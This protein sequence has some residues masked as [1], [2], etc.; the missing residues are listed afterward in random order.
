MK[1]ETDLHT[2]EL[3]EARPL[4]V[5][6][7]YNCAKNL[8]GDTNLAMNLLETGMRLLGCGAIPP[9]DKVRGGARASRCYSHVNVA[10]IEEEGSPP[11]HATPPPR[12][13]EPLQTWLPPWA[14]QKS[15]AIRRT[16]STGRD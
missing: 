3:T 10:R 4:S 6:G 16:T 12:S 11:S 15:P 2:T 8:A 5:A 9:R 13:A 7:Q 1:R 14:A